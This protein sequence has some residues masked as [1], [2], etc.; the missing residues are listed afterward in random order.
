MTNTELFA[1]LKAGITKTP[2]EARQ[3][4]DSL[5]IQ[6]TSLANTL[7]G[8][9]K[10]PTKAHSQTQEIIHGYND[11]C[12]IGLYGIYN[13]SLEIAVMKETMVAFRVPGTRHCVWNKSA[14][15][16]NNTY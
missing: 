3:K 6:E 2:T 1:Q 7:A 9:G 16:E 12:F 14:E 15:S 5:I 4:A 13:P 11:R 10:W 8:L